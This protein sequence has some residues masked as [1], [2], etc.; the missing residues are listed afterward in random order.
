M[1]VEASFPNWSNL[2]RKALQS[3]IM[4]IKRTESIHREVDII[5]NH[6]IYIMPSKSTKD[7]ASPKKQRKL[8]HI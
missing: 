4:R 2:H 5:T 7:H 1:A 3:R 6:T 8:Y